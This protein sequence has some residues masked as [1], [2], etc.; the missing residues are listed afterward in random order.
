MPNIGRRIPGAGQKTGQYISDDGYFDYLLRLIPPRCVGTQLQSYNLTNIQT[1]F[2]RT[3]TMPIDKSSFDTQ[4]VPQGE[5]LD[6]N[7]PIGS[8]TF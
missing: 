5:Y 6:Q 3:T 4:S 8:A 2:V 1:A 7:P